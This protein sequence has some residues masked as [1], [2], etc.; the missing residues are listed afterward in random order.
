[1]PGVVRDDDLWTARQRILREPL[2]EISG[3]P[4]SRAAHV[5]KIHR[6]RPDAWPLRPTQRL[7]LAAFRGGD[8]SADRAPAQP[9]GAERDGFEKTIVEF[10][11]L[12]ALDQLADTV[13]DCRRFTAVQHRLAISRATFEQLAVSGGGANA[14]AQ[15]GHTAGF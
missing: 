7:R 6:I 1:M 15:V 2:F 9:T 14:K 10:R 11:P 8:D 4:L 3:Q 12:L 13:G 5:V